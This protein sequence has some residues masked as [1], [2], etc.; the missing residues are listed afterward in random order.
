TTTCAFPGVP[1]TAEGASGTVRGVT[2]AE[3]PEGALGPA[4]FV[5]STVNVY[6][7]PFVRPLTRAVVAPVVEAVPP[8]GFEG[9]VYPVI[10][11]PPLKAGACQLTVAWALPAVA[12]TPVGGSGTV[13]GV[14]GSDAGEGVLEPATLM[15]T[16]VNV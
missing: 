6:D 15:A 8:G 14:T 12:V 16:T 4:T 11:L 7:V 2:A 9:T 5:A 3:A 10:G 1:V 13:R